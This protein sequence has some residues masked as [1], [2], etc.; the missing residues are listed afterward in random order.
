MQ[1]AKVANV[2]KQTINNLLATNMSTVSPKNIKAIATA[3]EISV[4][5][6]LYG[7]PDPYEPIGQEILTDL[8]TGDIRVHIQRIG[9]KASKK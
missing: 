8:F 3:L 2:P 1:L 7:G 6:L 9:R 4:H 5:E